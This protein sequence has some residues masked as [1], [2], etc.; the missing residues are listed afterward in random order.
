MI[1]GHDSDIRA[2][3][4]H[5]LLS[6]DESGN[7]DTIGLFD[8]VFTSNLNGFEDSVRL[9]LAIAK[10]WDAII[11]RDPQGFASATIPIL[12]VRELLE[13]LGES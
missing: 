12:S 4:E 2:V 11:T 10:S 1:T 5:R 7:F 9:A 6:R 3:R 8:V 13:Q